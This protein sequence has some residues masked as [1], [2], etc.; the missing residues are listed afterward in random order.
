MTPTPQLIHRRRHVWIRLDPWLLEGVKVL[1][2]D[3]TF[4]QEVG[5]QLEKLPLLL[6]TLGLDEA[7]MGI[8]YTDVKPEKGFAP[9]PAPLPTAE[10]TRRNTPLYGRRVLLPAE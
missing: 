9:K 5:M 8:F 10:D 6:E 2:W 4:Y 3:A 7:P 1:F